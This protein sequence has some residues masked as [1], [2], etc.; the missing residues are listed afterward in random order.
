[1]RLECTSESGTHDLLQLGWIHLYMRD[2]GSPCPHIVMYG[3]VHFNNSPMGT[4]RENTTN[5]DKDDKNLDV[6]IA[7][8]SPP[9]YIVSFAAADF[10]FSFLHE[11]CA[12]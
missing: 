10:F 12:P 8:V 6:E 3:E 4:R 9:G 5:S 7:Y 2:D 1:M 11:K